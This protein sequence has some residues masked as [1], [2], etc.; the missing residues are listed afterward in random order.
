MM[1]H[2]LLLGG[3]CCVYFQLLFQSQ[4]GWL[5]LSF[6]NALFVQDF[7]TSLRRLIENEECLCD[8]VYAVQLQGRQ[9]AKKQMGIDSDYLIQDNIF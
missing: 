4:I 1:H 9:G 7:Q 8:E 6:K 5:Q 2:W 3:S